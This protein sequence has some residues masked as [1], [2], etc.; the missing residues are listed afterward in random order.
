MQDDLS[1]MLNKKVDLVSANGLSQIIAP[2]IQSSKK[3]V[4]EHPQRSAAA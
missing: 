1:I 4:Y 2:Y 3:L